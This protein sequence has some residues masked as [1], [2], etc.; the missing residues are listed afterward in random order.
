[1]KHEKLY[2]PERCASWVKSG[3]QCVAC[4]GVGY[5]LVEQP[6]RRCSKCNGTGRSTG[7]R[8]RECL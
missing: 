7:L 2:K 5:L 8:C 4:M 1:M 6:S 3:Q